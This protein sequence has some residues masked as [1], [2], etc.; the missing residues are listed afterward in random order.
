MYMKKNL[1]FLVFWFFGFFIFRI[2]NSK[3]I[4]LFEK[5]RTTYFFCFLNLMNFI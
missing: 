4:L 5:P 2:A 1:L 3:L